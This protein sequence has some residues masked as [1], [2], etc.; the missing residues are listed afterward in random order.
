MMLR[1]M[2]VESDG[3]MSLV[4]EVLCVPWERFHLVIRYLTCFESGSFERR[5]S[6]LFRDGLHVRLCMNCQMVEG[7]LCR[8]VLQ[9]SVGTGQ[10]VFNPVLNSRLILFKIWSLWSSTD[11]RLD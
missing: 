6:A 8:E 10:G 11:S 1:V 7:C 4:R 2:S 3:G 9:W 5:W